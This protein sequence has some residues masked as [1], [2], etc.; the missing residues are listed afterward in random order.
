[1]GFWPRFL[2]A[3]PE[4]SPPR[5]AQ[6]WDIGRDARL[7]AFWARCAELMDT[8]PAREDNSGL[9]VLP[10]APEA[11]RI[12]GAY[13]ERMEHAAKS[14]SAPLHPDI[15]PF[16]VRA[17]EQAARIAGVLAVIAKST[18]ID[19]GA[20]RNG[21]ELATYSLETWRGI[22]GDRDA[23]RARGLAMKLYTWMLDR[24]GWATSETAI[25]R[26]G[27]KALRSKARHR[28]C[29]GDPRGPRTRQSRRIDLGAEIHVMSIRELIA[30][31]LDPESPESRPASPQNRPVEIRADAGESPDRPDRPARKSQQRLPSTVRR[32]RWTVW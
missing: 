6:P 10:M 22:F 24:P 28:Y 7:V 8:P 16:A 26:V 29:L 19:A 15:K 32:Y 11:R 18:M 14:R 30:D 5:S 12:L 21:I 23:T 25:L 17:S 3:W 27:P 1:M 31:I 13:F 9:H 2:V 20:V 4:P